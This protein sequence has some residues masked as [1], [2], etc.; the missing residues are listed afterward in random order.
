MQYVYSVEPTLTGV[1]ELIERAIYNIIKTEDN[2][3]VLDYDKKI[4]MNANIDDA[5]IKMYSFNNRYVTK[6]IK[7]RDML[8]KIMKHLEKKLK[9]YQG[10]LCQMYP[11]VFYNFVC[12]VRYE[13]RFDNLPEDEIYN[14]KLF[15][16]HYD[17]RSSVT[18]VKNPDYS[19]TTRQVLLNRIEEAQKRKR[20]L[21]E[22]YH[23]DLYKEY[24]KKKNAEFV[25]NG[26]PGPGILQQQIIRKKQTVHKKIEKIEHEKAS[27]L[28]TNKQR[29]RKITTRNKRIAA[30]QKQLVQ[31]DS[32]AQRIKDNY[33]NFI[34]SNNITRWRAY[35]APNGKYIKIHGKWVPNTKKTRKM[36]HISPK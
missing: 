5:N 15:T 2:N 20:L 19:P 30:L 23:S 33:E 6:Y 35:G 18:H 11:G 25:Q 22:Y 34:N 7:R 1:F 12:R 27:Y 32:N 16:G 29:D 21:K 36:K 26:I 10:L 4:Y 14:D 17:L 9:I 3:E 13:I 28:P 8:N 24:R 31:L